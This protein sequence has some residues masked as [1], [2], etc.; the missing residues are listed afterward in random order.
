MYCILVKSNRKNQRYPITNEELIDKKLT[1]TTLVWREGFEKWLHISNVSEL[2]FLLE[3]TPS[4]PN[5]V[6]PPL[7]KPM[8]RAG[9]DVHYEKEN[10][11]RPNSVI[12][13]IVLM[14][15]SSISSTVFSFTNGTGAIGE[16]L[17]LCCSAIFILLIY[18]RK[19]WA[20][21]A[22]LVFFIIGAL[23]SLAETIAVNIGG[24][25]PFDEAIIIIVM[26]IVIEVTDL[27]ALIL[28]FTP[29]SN[30]WFTQKNKRKNH[31]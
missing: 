17:F 3:T 21:I 6:T 9:I 16:I 12:W 30:R 23:L 5:V 4:L 15:V 25:L 20:R 24:L 13:A 27:I 10:T 2:S 11:D 14:T 7:P 8:E 22:C 19:N 29:S 28:L 18:H 1:R 26:W 31:V